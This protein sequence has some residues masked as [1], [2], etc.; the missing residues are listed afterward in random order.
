MSSVN[1]EAR[2]YRGRQELPT[3][4]ATAPDGSLAVLDTPAGQVSAITHVEIRKKGGIAGFFGKTEEVP[5]LQIRLPDQES[6][7][8]VDG[9]KVQSEFNDRGVVIF[10]D[11]KYVKDQGTSAS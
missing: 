6:L 3:L 2:Q 4:T 9:L 5:S 10:V 7:H 11:T 8:P 1:I